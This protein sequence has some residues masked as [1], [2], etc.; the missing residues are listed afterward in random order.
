MH[1]QLLIKYYFINKFDKSLIDKQNKHTII[2]YR[3]Y[4]KKADK[5]LISQ[6]RDYCKKKRIKFL[7]SNNIKMALGCNLDGAY[8]PSFNKDIK[9]LSFSYKKNFILVGSAHNLLE[10][11]NKELQGVQK[12]FVSSVFKF[13]KNYLGIFRFKQLSLLTKKKIIALGGISNQNLKKLL[14]TTCSGFAGIT[15]F[16]NKKKRPIN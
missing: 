12:I 9:H 1:N 2:I 14:M 5:N 3:N 16:E 7:L 6:I 15:F 8:I 13:N 4:T 11:R 10:L